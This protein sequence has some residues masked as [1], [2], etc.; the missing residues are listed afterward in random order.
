VEDLGAGDLTAFRGH[1]VIKH[2]DVTAAS[3]GSGR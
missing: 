3:H 1:A 2:Q